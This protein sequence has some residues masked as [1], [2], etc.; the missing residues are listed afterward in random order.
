[1]SSLLTCVGALETPVDA[2]V[3]V[4]ELEPTIGT[5]DGS[6][7]RLFGV[8]VLS[9]ETTVDCQAVTRRLRAVLTCLF[10]QT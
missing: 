4:A 3:F 9:I 8:F 6:D 2:V 5:T 10:N 1:M 7:R